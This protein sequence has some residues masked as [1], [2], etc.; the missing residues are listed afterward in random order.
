[1]FNHN[2]RIIDLDCHVS[3]EDKPG[4]HTAEQLLHLMD[5]DG[6]EKAVLTLQ[7]G[8]EM[9]EECDYDWLNAYVFAMAKKYPDRFI[10]MGWINPRLWNKE[11]SLERVK[12]FLETFEFKAIK[13]NP[14][15]NYFNY[16]DEERVLP[17]LDELCKHDVLLTFHCGPDERSH[18]RQ[19]E[20]IAARYPK[21]NMVMIHMGQTPEAA[22]ECI[23]VAAEHDNLYVCGTYME[24][25]SYVRKAVEALGS[26]RVCFGTDAPFRDH[27]EC[28]D[29]YLANLEGFS[30]EEKVDVMGLNTARLFGLI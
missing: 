10:P 27:A 8:I 17:V 11:E 2:Y 5:E 18:P 1:M 9:D 15:E 19:L 13:L 23:N 7:C 21:T 6:V 29:I 22:Q 28:I 4:A 24:D 16:M 20:K 25:Y 3:T 14:Y 12:R 26:K 30:Y